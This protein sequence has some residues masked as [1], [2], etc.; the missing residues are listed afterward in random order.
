MAK[1]FFDIFPPDIKASQRGALSDSETRRETRSPRRRRGEAGRRRKERKILKKGRAK[2]KSSVIK[3]ILISGGVFILLLGIFFYF[4]LPRL[5]LEIWPKAELLSFEE[6]ITI[7]KNTGE[8]DLLNKVIPGEILEEEKELWQEF[9]ATGTIIEEEEAEGII[10]V[11]NRYSPPVPITL[12]ATTRFL[13]DSG[14]NF[15]SLKK[16]YIPAA[17]VEGGKIVQS[18]TEIRVVAIETGEDYNIGPA[19]FSIPKLAGTPY[20]YTIYGESFTP[21][22]GGF[23]RESKQ[24]TQKD[25]QEA[26]DFLTKEL[27]ASTRASLK[28]K[29]PSGFV[30]FGDTISEEITEVSLFVK[31]G[32]VVDQFNVQAKAKA[33]GLIFKKSDLEKIAK[34]FILPEIPASKELFEESLNLSYTQEL[35]DL[36]EGKIILNLKFSAKIYPT[37]SKKELSVLFK[38][39]SIE[40]IREILYESLPQQIS[41][42]KIRFWPFWV[43][44]TPKNIEKINIKLNLE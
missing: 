6:K 10:R 9:P 20:Y 26:E 15:R 42:I 8:I 1:K 17:K 33:T 14:K 36:E 21:M 22:I 19:E 2:V 25:I 18:W 38:G 37:I 43:K 32:A 16:I 34:E 4:K 13:S 44:K 39:K 27:L 7:D 35:I 30:L 11:Y 3:E 29:V 28:N 23:K 24:V 41:Q 12:K 5:D 31:E 40:Q